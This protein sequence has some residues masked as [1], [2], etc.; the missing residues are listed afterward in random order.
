[1]ATE[2]IEAIKRAEL[3]AA[4]IERDAIKERD[5][6][7]ASAQSKSKDIID[8][9]TRDAAKKAQFDLDNTQKECGSFIKE[10]E[11]KASLQI[12]QLTEKLTQNREKVIEYIINEIA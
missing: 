6:I 3:E 9:M 8:E 1:M 5:A 4:K 7:L 10:A 2:A 11:E 12:K